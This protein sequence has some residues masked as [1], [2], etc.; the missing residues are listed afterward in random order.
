MKNLKLDKT[1]FKA[2]SFADADKN[3]LF[4]KNIG[5]A[6]RLRLAFDL[7]CRIYGI[8]ESDPL[9]INRSVYSTRKF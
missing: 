2:H 3:N 1:V 9:K 8:K 6:E 5:A 7:T 4:D